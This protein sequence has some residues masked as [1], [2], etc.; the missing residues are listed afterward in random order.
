MKSPICLRSHFGTSLEPGSLF[1][2][3]ST[4]NAVDQQLGE[5][6]SDAP[7]Q[8]GQLHEIVLGVV[9]EWEADV[10]AIQRLLGHLL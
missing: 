6:D 10:C 3:L 5:V 2:T 4:M 8:Q 7:E 9:K 1:G